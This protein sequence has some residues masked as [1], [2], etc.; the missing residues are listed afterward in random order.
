MSGVAFTWNDAKR[1]AGAVQWAEGQRGLIAGGIDSQPLRPGESWVRTPA[2]LPGGYTGSAALEGVGLLRL[3]DGT[4]HDLNAVWIKDPN[5]SALE[6][7]KVYRGT[8]NGTLSQADTNLPLYLVQAGAPAADD[9]KIEY[10][11]PWRRYTIHYP[12]GDGK[13]WT[14][15]FTQVQWLY[16]KS[17]R[18]FLTNDDI[19]NLKLPGDP[20]YT[21]GWAGDSSDQEDSDLRIF[22]SHPGRDIFPHY[23]LSSTDLVTG[24]SGTPS[25]DASYI[26]AKRMNAAQGAGWGRPLFYSMFR[27]AS[28]SNQAYIVGYG[29]ATIPVYTPEWNNNPAEGGDS[30]WPNLAMRVNCHPFRTSV[31][32]RTP[33]TRWGTVDSGT[34]TDSAGATQ[35]L[36]FHF[37]DPRLI[38]PSS[39]SGVN[40]MLDLVCN[41]QNGIVSG[42]RFTVGGPFDECD[43]FWS[44]IGLA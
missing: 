8:F 2:S 41:E 11:W 6:A 23:S 4:D 32:A 17:S 33:S 7:G 3:A 40:C 14:S 10:V 39:G 1:I 5:G 43:Y 22:I 25:I 37:Y 21:S 36:Y 18:Y 16:V 20:Y 28:T 35:H 27:P 44:P 19:R 29:G 31:T 30:F 9:R 15:S 26:A 42:G 13:F 34:F 12:E 24:W 38:L